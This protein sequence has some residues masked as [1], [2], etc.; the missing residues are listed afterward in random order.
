MSS[1][2][3]ELHCRIVVNGRREQGK[4]VEAKDT[5]GR[6]LPFFIWDIEF[7]TEKDNLFA[8]ESEFGAQDTAQAHSIWRFAFITD[9]AIARAELADLIFEFCGFFA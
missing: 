9:F 4:A 3:I 7:V 2:T 6:V 5:L 8:G 1:F